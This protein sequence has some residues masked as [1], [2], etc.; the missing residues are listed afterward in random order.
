MSRLQSRLT[1]KVSDVGLNLNN[2]NNIVHGTEEQQVKQEQSGR[3]RRSGQDRQ[4]SPCV[5]DR[6]KKIVLCQNCGST[7]HGRVKGRCEQHPLAI[8]LLDIACCPNCKAGPERLKEYG[9]SE[10]QQGQNP[11]KRR[12]YENETME[13]ED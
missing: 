4:K 7:F 5:C 3:R 8:F 1:P 2:N 9:D 10:P 11:V 13:T 6:P 12:K